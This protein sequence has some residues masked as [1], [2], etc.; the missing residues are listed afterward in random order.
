M[1]LPEKK[2]RVRPREP[3]R[4]F[5]EQ[6]RSD[7]S[8]SGLALTPLP[9]CISRCLGARQQARTVAATN[10]VV[11]YS[12]RSEPDWHSIRPG[13]VFCQRF[14]PPLATSTGARPPP[15]GKKYRACLPANTLRCQVGSSVCSSGR[16]RAARGQML[17]SLATDFMRAR[18]I[19][20]FTST[21]RRSGL[22]LED[23]MDE[24]QCPADL[25]RQR[26]LVRTLSPGPGTLDQ[27]RPRLA[28][29]LL[30]P[31]GRHPLGHDLAVPES[32]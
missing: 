14:T 12:V 9:A 23:M 19:S 1:N 8:Q 10:S 30:R 26:G 21:R 16:R 2:A 27:A 7:M 15:G 18:S 6:V 24:L 29:P 4:L 11:R 31:G 3:G 32:V 17:F 13:G 20:V 5:S 25:F 28:Q 22:R